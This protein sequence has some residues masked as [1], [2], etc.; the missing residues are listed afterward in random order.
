[1]NNRQLRLSSAALT[2]ARANFPVVVIDEG[3][4]QAWT[5]STELASHMNPKQ[6]ADA[7]LVR[8]ATRI[9][10][11]G[12]AVR[13]NLEPFSSVSLEGVSV[14]LLPH[15]SDPR[16]ER[17]TGFGSHLLDSDEIE[18]LVLHV[19]RGGGLVVLAEHENEKYGTNLNELLSRF[20]V[21]VTH[22]SV[23]DPVDNRNGVAAWVKGELESAGN[24]ALSRVGDVTFY[25]AGGLEVRES[26]DLRVLAR[27]GVEADPAGA[28]LL[29]TVRHGAGRL[30][31]VGDSDLFGDDSISD[32]DHLQLFSNLIT[33]AA[34]GGP[35]TSAS[36]PL[37]ELP[38]S[39]YTLKDRVEALRA[40]Q[41]KDGS[42]DLDTHGV[43]L[44]KEL[45]IAVRQAH[46]EVA[47]LHP[48]DAEFHMAV[49]VDLQKWIDGGFKTPDFLDSLMLFHPEKMR[50][51][52]LEHIICLPF[53]T[54]NG[55]PDRVFEAVWIRTVW[56]QWIA[57]LEE[58]GFRN[59]A[60]VPIS[61]VDFTS[62]YDTH[63]AVLFPETV[64]V[65]ETPK[66]TWGGIFCDREAARFRAVTSSAAEL[67]RLPLPA[68]AEMLLN[69]P[70]ITQET[71]VL[72]DLVH[73]RQH[74]LGELPFDPFMIKQRIPY[75]MY[76]LEELRCDLSAYAEM[77]R[78]SEL[79]VPHARLVKYAVLFDRLLRFPIT[80]QRVKN[81]DG[82]V[83]QI[84]FAHLH[85]TGVLR[86]ADNSLTIDWALVDASIAELSARINELY[87]SSID[88][89]RVGFW[90][91]AHQLV[92][93]LVPVHPGSRWKSGLDWNAAARELVDAVMPDEFPL[94]VFYESLNKKLGAVIESTRGATL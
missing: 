8:A 16:F 43:G 92:A 5:A 9:E 46:A 47:Q 86:W 11:D 15:F 20:G 48:H 79:G 77:D 75:W 40:V 88:R 39:W 25:R 93:E 38:L 54:Q 67:L 23:I 12:F 74:S 53:Y 24:G 13:R 82:L 65:R 7:S 30:V 85:R 21:S 50:T 91:A 87:R 42:V 68:D 66:F 3:H 78:L 83:G 61:F 51:D 62:G 6:P 41:A 17:T 70:T 80:G 60:F 18:S 90:S 84:L 94:N 89:S 29:V 81:Y 58:G 56:P 22:S 59:P 28:P 57:E 44:V 4:Q 64:S 10:S 32:G 35:G 33:W 55:N 31:V 73:D 45:A 69:D 34:A 1:M 27:S 19:E 14:V 72:W 36:K 2:Q 71:Y 37:R 49:Q 26:D 63:S 52:G 76:S